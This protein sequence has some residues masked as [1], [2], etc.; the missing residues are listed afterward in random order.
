[1]TSTKQRDCP[2]SQFRLL[3][4]YLAQGPIGSQIPLLIHIE[5][6]VFPKHMLRVTCPLKEK[7]KKKSTA[8]KPILLG[9]PKLESNQTGLRLNM[10]T[11]VNPMPAEALG[12]AP[13]SL[14]TL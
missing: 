14:G 5:L 8:Y 7:E 12:C 9:N 4:C 3:Y 13:V 1:M 10:K 2:L 11:L 6:D